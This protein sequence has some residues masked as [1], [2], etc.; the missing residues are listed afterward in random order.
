[1]ADWFAKPKLLNIDVSDWTGQTGQ[2]IRVLAQDDTFVANVHVLIKDANGNILEQRQASKADGLWWNYT[3][4]MNLPTGIGLV[5]TA[6][7]EDLPGNNDQ[8]IWQ[9][10]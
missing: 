4:T 2:D 1:M 10:N 9:N 7:A 5:V 8:M 6:T 3:T